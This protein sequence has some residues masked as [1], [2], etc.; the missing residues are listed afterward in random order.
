MDPDVA[1]SPTPEYDQ[2]YAAGGFGY[3]ERRDHWLAWARR[4]YVDAFDLPRGSLLDVGCGD[5]FWTSIF[6]EL[7][8][9]TTGI[10][11]SPGGIA[12]ATSKYPAST[13][14][15]ADADAPLPFAPASFDVVFCRAISH[16]GEPDLEAPRVTSLIPR[17]MALVAPGGVL[18]ASYHTIRD[19]SAVH[20]RTYHPVSA[21]VR[22]LEHGGDPYRVELVGNYVQ[23]GVRQPGTPP[24]PSAPAAGKS[25]GAAN[26][27]GNRVTELVRRVVRKVRRR[28]R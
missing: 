5:G 13:F 21:L 8:Y 27:R 9:E 18:L 22:L 23:I 17:L 19:G 16:F 10:D 3:E 14:R 11:V 24:R 15:V 6:R 4:H 28:L 20:G 1:E 7:G 26:R 2:L 12:A 25:S